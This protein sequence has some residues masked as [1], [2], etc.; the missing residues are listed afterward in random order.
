MNEE[1]EFLKN[2]IEAAL[3]VEGIPGVERQLL[4]LKQEFNIK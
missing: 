2:R 3:K 4:V 1:G